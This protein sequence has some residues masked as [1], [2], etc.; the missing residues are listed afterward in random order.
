VGR[1]SGNPVKAGLSWRSREVLLSL[2]SL[3]SGG[4][5]SWARALRHRVLHSCVESSLRQKVSELIG[6]GLNAFQ[7]SSGF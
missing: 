3:S 7:N 4:D 1:P 6:L 2:S 5:G